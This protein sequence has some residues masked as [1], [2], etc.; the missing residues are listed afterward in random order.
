MVKKAKIPTI[1]GGTIHFL[2]NN[3]QKMGKKIMEKNHSFWEKIV[4]RFFRRF[5]GKK[6]VLDFF[7]ILFG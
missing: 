6:I 1:L 5:L 3:M 2:P 4:Y 7:M